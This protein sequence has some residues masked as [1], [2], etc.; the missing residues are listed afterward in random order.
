MKKFF[1]TTA[2]LLLCVLC[3]VFSVMAAQA[4]DA[5]V[6]TAAV[7]MTANNVLSGGNVTAHCPKCDKDVT[8]TPLDIL[9]ADRKEFKDGGHFYLEKDVSNKGFYFFHKNA[10]LHL[11]GH[12]ITS[13][14]RAIYAETGAVL[15]IMGDGTVT[16]KGISNSTCD[17]GGALDIAGVANLYGGTY[18]HTGSYPTVVSRGSSGGI[19]IYNGTRITGTSGVSGNNVRIHV[20]YLKV[21]GGVIE[22][23]I[24]DQGGNIYGGKNAKIT[25]AGGT[26]TGG[27]VYMAETATSLTLTGAP[28]VHV[29]NNFDGPKANITGLTE[30]ADIQMVGQGTLTEACDNIES[31][32][33]YISSPNELVKLSVKDNALFATVDVTA[34]STAPLTDGKT[35]KMLCLTSSFGLN[36][37]ELLYDIAKAEGFEDV[38]VARLYASGCT[39][40]KH[41]NSYNTDTGIYWYTKFT[42]DGK[43]E[44][45][46][47]KLLDGLLDEDW[48]II[49]IQQGAEQTGQLK[50]YMDYLDQLLDIVDAHKTNADAKYIWNMTWAFQH[51]NDRKIFT[52]TF[53]GDQ[54]LMHEAIIDAMQEKIL[55]RPEFCVLLPTGA[56]VQ[57]ARSSYFGDRLTKDTLH[58]NNLGR[59]V[60]G[61]AVLSTLLD[62]D[63]TEV[64]VGSVSSYDLTTSIRISETDRKVIIEAVN[65]ARANPFAVI[66]SKYTPEYLNTIGAQA[67]ALSFTGTGNTTA[68]CPYCEKDVTWTA[69]TDSTNRVLALTD[70]NWGHYYLAEDITYSTKYMAVNDVD[71]GGHSGFCL[72]L[73]GHTIKNTGKRGFWVGAGNTLN[74]MGE[75]TIRGVGEGTKDSDWRGAA[76]D[77]YGHVNLF[78]GNITHDAAVPAVMI[79]G[80]AAR[81]NLFDG[82]TITGNNNYTVSLVRVNATGS[83]FN[84]FGGIVEGGKAANGG[85]IYLNNKSFFNI[86]GGIVRNGYATSIG[87]NVYAANGTVNMYGGEIYGGYTTNT[88][89]SYGRGGNVALNGNSSNKPVFNM[90]GGIIGSETVTG[91]AAGYASAGGANLYVANGTA[92]ILNDAAVISGGYGKSYGGNI[93]VSSNAYVNLNKG[94]VKNGRS[95]LGGN[96][97]LAGTSSNFNQNGGVIEN[98][99]AT[100]TGGNTFVNN[101]NFVM[102][103]G[104]SKGGTAGEGG[105]NLHLKTGKTTDSNFAE[106]HYDSAVAAAAPVIT[107]GEVLCAY[108][109]NLGQF[110]SD[111]TFVMNSTTNLTLLADVTIA[112]CQPNQVTLD[113]T[114]YN[115]TISGSGNITVFDSANEDLATYGQLTLTGITLN[116]PGKAAF[117]GHDYYTVT[118]GNVHSFHIL[119]MNIAS[120]ALR[121][122]AAGI[123]FNGLWKCDQKL[124]ESVEAYGVAVSLHNMPGSDFATDT[125]EDNMW[126]SY[127]GLESGKAKS[128]V[129]ITGILK[130]DR[131]PN[132]NAAYSKMPISAV[133]YITLGGNTYV[134]E[135]VQMSLCDVVSAL[136]DRVPEDFLAYW[137]KYGFVI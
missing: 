36:T 27:T 122:S 106:I 49:Y 60:A 79:R 57:N 109:L 97:Y 55:T 32:A 114:G 53:K 48:D 92:N 38:I 96:V 118:E 61:Y 65:A 98:G 62:R 10:C 81:V 14:A 13:T 88:S 101:G 133:A 89:S 8:W 58:L 115:A 123:Y 73:N 135:G 28:K 103:G 7:E 117:N 78:G 128:G 1:L 64:N 56:A 84:V 70:G 2:L 37:T 22:N 30:G 75:G 43:Y 80:G 116:N 111:A 15:N 16:G 71:N 45:N 66:Q 29:I 23:G 9:T 35:L 42:A 126:S 19:S 104:T 4:G 87:G 68:Y 20:S 39:L 34:D 86:F 107:G 63:L 67:K 11:N 129:L 100:G 131:D 134:S 51:D 132:L 47:A 91:E 112:S 31:C 6:Y 94:T 74:I 46:D 72:H 18:K 121:P 77:V 136:A 82:A 21:Y 113:L 102:A 24:A 17:R 40:Q 95:N 137:T 124:A 41:V 90:Y 93:M 130:E 50:T 12:N 52:D 119:T 83:E 26:I 59:V 3:T 108:N 25:I 69:F 44:L 127:T 120:V 125:E 105:A 85:N 54:M 76:F 99:T 33:A 110:T 5:D